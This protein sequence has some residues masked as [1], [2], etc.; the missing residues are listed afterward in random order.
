MKEVTAYM[1]FN[2]R[3]FES[4]EKC[5][6][7]EAK[8]K[9]YPSVKFYRMKQVP[10][11]KGERD[12]IFLVTKVTYF[13]P[14][15]REKEEWI[16]VSINENT[17]KVTHFPK[18]EYSVFMYKDNWECL[19]HTEIVFTE[20]KNIILQNKFEELLDSEKSRNEFIKKCYERFEELYL[21]NYGHRRE[22]SFEDSHYA[23]IVEK[24]NESLISIEY[25]NFTR[26]VVS[27]LGFKIEKIK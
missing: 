15:N 23:L 22:K 1:S 26:G 13:S 5:E 14:S 25:K 6:K 18:L 7:Y 9:K 12:E 4:K 10:N 2:G 11:S 17:Y 19:S 24:V 16:E 21:L 20:M 3:L 8:M 27:P